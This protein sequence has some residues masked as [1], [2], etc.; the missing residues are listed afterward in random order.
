MENRKCGHSDRYYFLGLQNHCGW[1]LQPRNSKTFPPWRENYDK[2]AA[3]AA[4][5]SRQAC[6]TLCDPR[7]GSPP[8]SPVPGILQARTLEW[9]AISFSVTNLGSALKSKGITS[10][11][12]IHLV[13]AIVLPVV[14]YG[15]EG[16]TTRK[17]EHQ[18]TDAFKLW[19]WRRLLW[20]PWT[21]RR[22][23]QSV[24]KEISP[25]CPLEGLMLKLNLQYFGHLMRSA[26]SLEK[27]LIL[28]KIEG[29]RRRGR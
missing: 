1:W 21:A 17:A 23:N 4:A 9:V 18:R 29:K 14:M 3:A 26:G 28:G 27:A 20:V 24:L 13:K 12:K 15:C 11:T 10:P 5:A 7:D 22:S 8:G 2:P 16:W 6:P 19:F 25:E